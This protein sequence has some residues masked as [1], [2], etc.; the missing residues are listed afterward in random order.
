[1][2]YAEM[3]EQPIDQKGSQIEYQHR[4]KIHITDAL[5]PARPLVCN[6][7]DRTRY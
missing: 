7:Y 3:T 2:K 6:E 5:V 1:M 4:N